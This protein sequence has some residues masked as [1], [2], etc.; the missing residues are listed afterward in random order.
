MVEVGLKEVETYLSRRQNTFAQFIA[1]S[2]IMYLCM[3]E[4]QRTGSMVPKRWWEQDRIG[5]EG[6]RKAAR[7]AERMD[8]VGG[9]GRDGDRLSRR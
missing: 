7:E 9:D 3:A 5:V 4:E 6:M 8:G 1:N 2:P